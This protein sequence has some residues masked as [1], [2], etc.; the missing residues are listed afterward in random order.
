MPKT[1]KSSVPATISR[2]KGTGA[3]KVRNTLYSLGEISRGAKVS[4]PHI[5]RIFNGKRGLS[6][7]AAEKIASFLGIPIDALLGFLKG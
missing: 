5:T 6:L 3:I 2:D 7:R 4:R 1:S